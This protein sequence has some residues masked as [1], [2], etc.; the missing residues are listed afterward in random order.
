MTERT[1]AVLTG[2]DLKL[3][4]V[5]AGVTQTDLARH[6]GVWRQTVSV[7]EGSLRPRPRMV[8]HYLRALDELAAR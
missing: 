5:E 8:E 3:R 4:R 1:T 6:M 7:V 2:L